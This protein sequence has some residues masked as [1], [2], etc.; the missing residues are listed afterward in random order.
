[1]ACEGFRVWERSNMG[2]QQQWRMHACGGAGG[3]GVAL[4]PSFFFVW[5]MATAHDHHAFKGAGDVM[6]GMPTQ[7]QAFKAQHC[8][9][10][11]AVHC[12]TD[13]MPVLA[14]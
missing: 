14:A 8:S 9:S 13:S 10:V 1:M 6:P 3:G 11:L 5:R 2:Q 7:A 4:R 12:R